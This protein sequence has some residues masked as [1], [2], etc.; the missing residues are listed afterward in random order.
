MLYLHVYKVTMKI[1]GDAFCFLW[2]TTTT[3]T[4]TTTS[5]ITYNTSYNERFVHP[6]LAKLIELGGAK[7]KWLINMY[8]DKDYERKYLTFKNNVNAQ[9]RQWNVDWDSS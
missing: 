6:H 2:T 8:N 1:V 4:T 9:E 5:F 7:I 3:T